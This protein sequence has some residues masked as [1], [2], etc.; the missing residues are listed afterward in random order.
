MCEYNHMYKGSCITLFT[1]RVEEVWDDHGEYGQTLEVYEVD[2][3]KAFWRR[4]CLSWI[5]WVDTYY[6]LKRLAIL[7]SH[8]RACT[9]STSV[10]MLIDYIII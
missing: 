8:L 3:R 2:G 1:R 10:Y 5:A 6:R 4:S 9:F 7:S